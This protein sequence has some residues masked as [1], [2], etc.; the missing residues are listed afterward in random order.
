MFWFIV[1]QIFSFVLDVVALQGQPDREKDL[2]ILLLRQQLRIV[3]RKPGQRR[4]LSHCEKLSLAVLL[5]WFKAVSRGGGERLREVMRLFQPQT[6]LKWHRE[7]VKRKWTYAYAPKPRGNAP[8]STV[9]ETLIVQLARDNARFGYKKLVGELGKLGHRV[10]RSTVRDVLKRHGIQPAPDR[11]HRSSHWC[12]FLNSHKDSVL[13]CD[14]FTVETVWLQTRYVLFFIELNTRR[15]YVASCTRQPTSAWV[16]QQ[17][18][19][20]VWD[21]QTAP[22]PLRF[23]IHD[24]DSKFSAR[25]DTVFMSEGIEIVRTPPQTPNANA[26]AERWA[27]TVREECL[28]HFLVLNERHLGQVLKGCLAYYNQTRPHQGLQQQTPIPYTPCKPQRKIR[29]RAVLGGL[30]RDYYREAA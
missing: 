10:G 21:V 2:E 16:I 7:L 25:F 4:G 12:T 24:R 1:A 13:A 19:Q 15:V 30:I 17:A 5:A 29:H 27:R 28:D 18:R 26:Y 20:F 3:E 22:S 9:L 6:V 11:A 23:L 14:F 8:L